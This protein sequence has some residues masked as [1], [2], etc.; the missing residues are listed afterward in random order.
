MVNIHIY[1]YLEIRDLA[2]I[3]WIYI[4]GTFSEKRHKYNI[5]FF[6]KIDFSGGDGC[7]TIRPQIPL[8]L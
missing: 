4:V 1:N 5:F 6:K 2:K 3:C 7:F 8:G